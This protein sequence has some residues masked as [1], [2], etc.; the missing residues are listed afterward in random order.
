MKGYIFNSEG[1]CVGVIIGREIFDLHG[2][3]LY[4]LKGTNIYR[5]SGELVGHLSDRS[6]SDRRLDKSTDRL[7][8]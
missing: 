3:K 5:L 2:T 6:G 1:V 4:D 8:L 7:F